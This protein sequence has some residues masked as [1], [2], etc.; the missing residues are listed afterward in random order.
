MPALKKEKIL[1]SKCSKE[2]SSEAKF[3]NF[4]GTPRPAEKEE[5]LLPKAKSP[6]KSE[7]VSTLKPGAELETFNNI[8][9]NLKNKNTISGFELQNLSLALEQVANKKQEA[10]IKTLLVLSQN[11]NKYLTAFVL[12]QLRE[13]SNPA[14]YEKFLEKYISTEPDLN[15]STLLA[16]EITLPE[17]IIMQ[18]RR[19]YQENNPAEKEWCLRK[20][21]KSL[22]KA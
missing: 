2:L 8:V 12:E 9:E 17:K 15:I 19:H 4:C 20:L 10:V 5:T 6:A 18:I 7:A 21:E 3:C 22:T 16:A 11:K 14:D 13:I 1:C